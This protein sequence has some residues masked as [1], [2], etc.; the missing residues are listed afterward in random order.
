MGFTIIRS[1]SESLEESS[2]IRELVERLYEGDVPGSQ[3]NPGEGA[4]F[5]YDEFTLEELDCL[6]GPVSKSNSP[7]GVYVDTDPIECGDY[8]VFSVTRLATALKEHFP[9]EDNRLAGENTPTQD[10]AATI[11][12]FSKNPASGR[13]TVVIWW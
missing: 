3:L 9:T 11:F 2:E 8:L 12:E 1:N 5:F 13:P 10:L 4:Q 6:L 7:I